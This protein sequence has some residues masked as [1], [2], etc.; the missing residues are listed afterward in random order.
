MKKVMYLAFIAV[1]SISMVSCGDE[2][3]HK[4]EHKMEHHKDHDA[5]HKDH[6]AKES[7][8]ETAMAYQ[9]PMDCEKGK[10]YEHEGKCPVCKMALKPVKTDA[11]IGDKSC[12]NAQCV[13]ETDCSQEKE[14]GKGCECGACKAA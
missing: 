11:K 4:E 12:G 7:K 5:D 13:C 14:E 2:K 6:D 1:L 3:K 8:D 10:T 9:C